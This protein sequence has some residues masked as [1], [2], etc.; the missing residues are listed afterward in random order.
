MAKP[1]ILVLVCGI[2]GRDKIVGGDTAD[3][4]EWPWQILLLRNNLG[5]GRRGLCGGAIITQSHVITAAHC[6]YYV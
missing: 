5:G 6:V 1:P 4:G 3:K 2:K